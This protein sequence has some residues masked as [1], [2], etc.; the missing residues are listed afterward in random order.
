MLKVQSIEINTKQHTQPWCYYCEKKFGDES[1]LIQHQKEK[2][3]RCPRCERRLNNAI[4]LRNHY[5][6]QHTMEIKKVPGALEHRS[7]FEFE[8]FGMEGVPDELLSEEELNHYGKKVTTAMPPMMPMFGMPPFGMPPFGMPGMPMYPPMPMNV[9][10]MPPFPGMPG[11]MP[12]IPPPGMPPM[13]PMPGYPGGLEAP[14]MPFPGAVPYPPSGLPNQSYAPPGLSGIPSYAPGGSAAPQYAP[15]GPP[16]APPA[17]SVPKETLSDSVPPTSTTESGEALSVKEEVYAS[18]TEEQT[19]VSYSKPSD[20][21]TESGGRSYYKGPG[22][23]NYQQSA[24]T[25]PPK[26]SYS[27]PNDPKKVENPIGDVPQPSPQE[28]SQ[29]VTI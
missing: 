9:P 22:D 2:H 21:G 13:P 7:T 29:R 26:K 19:D 14:P 23:S 6:K 15:G 11:M 24:Y 12:P 27:S 28:K 4:G 3:F 10:G 17:V 18:N 16:A 8:V 20:D 1:M 25:S 5:V